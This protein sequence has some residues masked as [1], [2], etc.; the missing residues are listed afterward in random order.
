MTERW[1][2]L[3]KRT[4]DD[5][6]TV[7]GGVIAPDRDLALLLAKESFF[8]HGEG[9]DLAVVRA[10]DIHRFGDPDLMT[11]ATDKSYRT[12]AG[13][14]GLGEKNKMLPVPEDPTTLALP[15]VWAAG[16]I[17]AMMRKAKDPAARKAYEKTVETVRKLTQLKDPTKSNGGIGSRP[18]RSE[19]DRLGQADYRRLATAIG[20]ERG[21][22]ADR[23]QADFDAVFK[24]MRE[25]GVALRADPKFAALT[26]GEVEVLGVERW[27]LW[28]VSL[29]C[30]MKVLPH[31]RDTVRREFNR[32]LAIEF[33][34]RGLKTA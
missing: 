27:E 34:Q 2:V 21:A 10:A 30:R 33:Q 15:E 7:V 14:A 9:I 28:G 4:P 29:R 23:L 12:Q 11:P 32:R 6:W 18:A 8:R 5:P 26:L 22:G 16:R 31:E 13:Y 24:A 1:E 3:G 17:D 20:R 19:S 25:V